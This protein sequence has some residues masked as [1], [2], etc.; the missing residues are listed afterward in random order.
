MSLSS[1]YDQIANKAQFY[2]GLNKY[3]KMMELC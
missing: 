2:Y 3:A 1:L